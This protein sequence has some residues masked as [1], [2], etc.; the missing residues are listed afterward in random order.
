M[1]ATAL[2]NVS[3]KHFITIDTLLDKRKELN[4]EKKK[5]LYNSMGNISNCEYKHMLWY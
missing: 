3:D 5:V 1:K 2:L 4:S